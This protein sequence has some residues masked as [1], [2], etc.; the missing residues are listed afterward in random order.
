MRKSTRAAGAIMLATAL[1]VT[2][3]TSTGAGTGS[4][5]G[6][7]RAEP[8]GQGKAGLVS[9]SGCD[10][11]LAGL[12][13]GMRRAV[14]PGGLSGPSTSRW[15]FADPAANK[16][17]DSTYGQITTNTHETGVDE[18][19]LVKTDGNR[20]I[21]VNHGVLRVV[22]TRS[23]KVTGT[24]RL[25]T[26]NVRNGPVNLLVS[27][28]R[29]LVLF[30]GP[31]PIPFGTETKR[32]RSDG[33]RYVLVDLSGKPE[34]IGMLA[35]DGSQVDARMVGSTVRVVVLSEPDVTFPEFGRDLPDD[36]IT[37]RN[38]EFL[39]QIPIETWLPKYDLTT[40][41]GE[42]SRHTVECGKISHPEK[43]SGTSMLTV[44]TIDLSKP[45]GDT[46][47][48]GVVADGDTVHGTASSLY[49]TSDLR[50]WGPQAFE[51]SFVQETPSAT[52]SAPQETEVHRFDITAAGEPRYVASGRVPG[53]VLNHYS[54]SEHDGH[55]RVATT[56]DV[57]DPGGSARNGSAAVHVLDAGT[58]GVAGQV[59]GLGKGERIYSVRFV[60]PVGYAMTFEPVDPLYTLDLSDPAKPRTAGE[61]KIAGYSTYLHPA[62]DGRL[63]GVGQEASEKGRTLGTQISL[64]DIGDP[65]DPRRLSQMFPKDS[66]AKTRRNHP[67][68]FL[69]WARTGLAV[70]PL[71]TSTGTGQTNG[72]ALVLTIGESAISKVGMINHPRPRRGDDTIDWKSIP[73]DIHRSVVIGD[74]LWA[75][76]E[77][78]MKVND[79][80][81]LADRAWI[82][83]S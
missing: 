25:L 54:L 9:Y 72:A 49:V 16:L 64:F 53:R 69:Y 38:T 66:G 60:G 51:P 41:D 15:R 37:R 57:G 12:H 6:T 14:G 82:P 46:S 4:G 80:K 78:G 68:T 55:L 33:P 39:A 77:V 1:F 10:D 63:I 31:A 50:W 61:L 43:Y 17:A 76:S 22:D 48:I 70:L 2:A 5:S 79:L 45:F 47:P 11:M 7:G 13:A 56:S 59:G 19:D 3:C 83:F 23:R 34:M 73:W 32:A 20:L 44:H 58:L 42:T 28:D 35:P 62:G 30:P 52:A 75:V 65:A 36:E 40:A 74:S 26:E 71:E 29:A 27:G 67:H 24:L 8:T 18:P 21:T 81:T